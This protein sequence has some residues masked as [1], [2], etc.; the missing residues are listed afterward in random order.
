MSCYGFK[1]KH[2]DSRTEIMT[3]EKKV[4]VYDIE[5]CSDFDRS[6]HT[7]P[8][9]E[10]YLVDDDIYFNLS[11]FKHCN[12]MKCAPEMV[13]KN[14]SMMKK[15]IKNFSNDDKYKIKQYRYETGKNLIKMFISKEIYDNIVDIYQKQLQVNEK[16]LNISKN[17]ELTKILN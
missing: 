1:V 4:Y 2:S 13:F 17:P 10:M 9:K 5:V 16:K 11:S 15:A 14:E 7:F 12:I 3:E 6:G 8:I